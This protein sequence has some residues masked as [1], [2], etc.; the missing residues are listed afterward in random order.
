[1][2]VYIAVPCKYT[3]LTRCTARVHFAGPRGEAASKSQSAPHPHVLVCICSNVQQYHRDHHY[4]TCV[5]PYN[6]FHLHW[7]VLCQHRG[8]F[9]VQHRLGDL[10]HLLAIEIDVMHKHVVVAT[11]R[12]NIG[13]PK[14]GLPSVLEPQGAGMAAVCPTEY[15]DNTQAITLAPDAAH[16]LEAQVVTDWTGV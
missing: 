10:G 6:C 7:P 14:A 12:H 3:S 13:L 5:L 16:M 4:D 11:R 2:R 8:L 1:M 9:I 15:V